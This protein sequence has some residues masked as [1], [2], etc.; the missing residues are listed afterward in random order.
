MLALPSNGWNIE[1]AFSAQ[2]SLR[3]ELG[4][5]N[6]MEGSTLNKRVE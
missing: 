1:V 6:F 3:K 2:G 5:I 4:I